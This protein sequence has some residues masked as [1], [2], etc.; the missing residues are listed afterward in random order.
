MPKPS[1]GQTPVEQN[2]SENV[3][4]PQAEL[5]TTHQQRDDKILIDLIED[6]E[7]VNALP[8][9]Q[10]WSSNVRNCPQS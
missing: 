4:L 10:V 2:P 9:E 5:I 6:A 3:H 1:V 7:V 8:S